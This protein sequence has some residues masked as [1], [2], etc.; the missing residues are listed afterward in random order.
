MINPPEQVSKEQN[1]TDSN[2]KQMY[3]QF[4]LI[5]YQVIQYHVQ[6]MEHLY[7]S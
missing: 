3:Q 1:T 6:S 2:L 7:H 5:M 4:Q